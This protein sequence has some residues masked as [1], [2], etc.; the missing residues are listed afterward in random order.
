M[1]PELKTACEV[2]FQEHKLSS[3]INW[4]R[5]AFR[6]QISLG[7]SEL[8]K[9]TLVRKNIIVWPNKSRKVITL[10][11]PAVA[12][13]TSFEEAEKMI[14][15]KVEPSVSSPKVIHPADITNNVPDLK[16]SDTR[17]LHRPLVIAPKIHARATEMKWYMRPLFYYV[18]W[19]FCGVVAGVLI[20][21]LIDFTYTKLFLDLK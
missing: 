7:L 18:V 19:P 9:E 8:A 2:V 13:A 11:N 14:S 20:T 12:T 21:F 3:Q 4:G 17:Q 10:L 6:G 16:V 15:N 1:T 5:D